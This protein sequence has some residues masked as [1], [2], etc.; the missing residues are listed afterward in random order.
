MET[1]TNC[2]SISSD[3]ALG[4]LNTLS[5]G[6]TQAEAEKRFSSF[7]PNRLP[8]APK[9][10]A[11]VRFFLYF[12]NILIYVLLG[13]ALITSPLGH[14]VDTGVILAVVLVN[15]IIGFIQEGK[16]EE[17]WMRSGTKFLTLTP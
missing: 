12:H 15:G 17:Q 11:F 8:Q 9:R 10:S 5:N 6:L 2:H 4:A 7:G 14:W 16:T 3:E 1:R 13:A